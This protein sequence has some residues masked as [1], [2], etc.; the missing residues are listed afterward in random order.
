MIHTKTK[1]NYLIEKVKYIA[2][3]HRRFQTVNIEDKN[4]NRIKKDDIIQKNKIIKI[5]SPIK[6]SDKIK[7]DLNFIKKSNLNFLSKNFK[8]D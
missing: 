5:Q 1:K 8:K 3:N 2:N 6:N 4:S 7:N